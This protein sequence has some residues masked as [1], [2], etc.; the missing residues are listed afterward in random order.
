MI[1]R[2]V[3]INWFQ[4]WDKAPELPRACLDSWSRRNPDWEI[5]ALSN[6]TVGD[7]VDL[8]EDHPAIRGKWLD[9]QAYSDMLRISLL[10]RY[11]G[12]WADATV[13]CAK[14][15]DL[16]LDDVTRS[17][18][19]AFERP[20]PDRM[21]S[22]WFLAACVDSKAIQQWHSQC[23]NYWADRD[24]PDEYFWFHYNFAEAYLEGGPVSDAWNRTPKLPALA[25]HR[26][27][28][29]MDHPV[30]EELRGLLAGADVP[31]YKLDHR[32]ERPEVDFETLFDAITNYWQ[33]M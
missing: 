19:F 3:W 30:T 32:Q 14:P 10:R 31:V 15:L 16:W 1:P 7:Y 29:I 11:G 9:A 4:G 5:V 18:F 13:W 6:R 22:S 12:V 8:C 28:P 24:S 23:G 25:P 26:L 17:G 21:L 27:Q 33:T 2:I 20:A